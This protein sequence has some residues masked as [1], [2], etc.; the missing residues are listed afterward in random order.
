METIETIELT[1]KKV[2][3]FPNFQKTFCPIFAE[4]NL[5]HRSI[6]ASAVQRVYRKGDGVP[7]IMLTQS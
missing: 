5:V 3:I 6:D 4:Q 1:E 7:G 2:A